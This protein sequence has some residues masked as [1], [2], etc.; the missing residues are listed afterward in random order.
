MAN[1]SRS[2]RGSVHAINTDPPE[3]RNNHR[4]PCVHYRIIKSHCDGISGGES[5]YQSIDLALREIVAYK[6]WEDRG[7]LYT[8]IREWAATAMPGDVFTTSVSA[9]VAVAPPERRPEDPC[10]DCGEEGLR[11]SWILP[12]EAGRLR[13]IVICPHC[14]KF[15]HDTL[16]LTFLE[17][18]IADANSHA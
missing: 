18:R 3:R 16:A 8:A 15:F 17:R 7:K 2:S 13:Q 11:L 1:R 4:R 5:R 10:P 6:G 9:I 14:R 12:A